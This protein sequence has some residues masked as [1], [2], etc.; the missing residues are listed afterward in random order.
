M[1]Q[2]P[3]TVTNLGPFGAAVRCSGHKADGTAC[4]KLTKDMVAGSHAA[5]PP[6]QQQVHDREAE[7]A[8]RRSLSTTA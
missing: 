4:R 6:H 2:T 3:V 7:L 8:E 1:T 5:C